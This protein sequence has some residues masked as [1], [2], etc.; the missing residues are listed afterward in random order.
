MLLLLC[1]TPAP[2]SYVKDL[3]NKQNDFT[4]VD[5]SWDYGPFD[6]FQRPGI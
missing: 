3:S 1:K 2:W 6:P 4:D 5:F